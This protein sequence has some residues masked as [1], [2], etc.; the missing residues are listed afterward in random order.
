MA[1]LSAIFTHIDE[2]SRT[3]DERLLSITKGRGVV[4]RDEITAKEARADTLVGYKRCLRGDIVVNQ[5]SAFEGLLGVSAWDGIVT[6]HYLV[7][8]P[9]SSA[10]DARFYAYLLRTPTY[11]LDFSRRVRGLGGADQSN[12]RTPHIRISDW[13][14]T[15]VPVPTI[16][17]QRGIA[18][19]LDRETARIDALI[20]A[21][22]RMA[23]LIDE[24]IVAQRSAWY[25]RLAR[26]W[27][28]APLRRSS[29]RIEQGWSPQ[30]ENLPAEE[31]DWGVLKTSAVSRGTFMSEENKR[32]PDSETPDLRWVVNDGDLLV[33]RGSG[34]ATAVGQAA[35]A[36]VG[37]QRLLLSDLIYRIHLA[38]AQP[39]FIAMALQSPQ[40]RSQLEG[41]IRTD[42]GQTLKIRTDDVRSLLT[43][44]VPSTKQLAAVQEI[45]VAVDF[46]HGI[47]ER[48]DQSVL[49]LQE[50][51]DAL[52]T[53]V[54]T[55]QVDVP[56]AA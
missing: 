13:L 38:D 1:P 6:Y 53:A 51:R 28:S 43:P 20:A 22:R 55:G 34:S 18:D 25:S 50:L 54:V 56:E 8:R 10:C 39:R 27:G 19:Y 9:R 11:V 24:W 33:V 12:V 17:I 4:P 32:L 7:F 3:G 26:E 35:V 16:S 29:T 47:C 41:A 14:R 21:K 30:C 49:L 52:I 46:A 15:V 48:L 36:E 2:R 37:E 5:M 44:S 40:V 31:G 42:A 23:E 45:A